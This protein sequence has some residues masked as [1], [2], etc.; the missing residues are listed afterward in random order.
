MNWAEVFER[1]VK[2]VET[3]CESIKTLVK[4]AE[5]RGTSSDRAG[6]TQAFYDA[7]T[8]PAGGRL[9]E[10][11]VAAAMREHTAVTGQ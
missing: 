11:S 4:A 9:W 1:L 10:I 3:L 7:P 6:T 5:A 2:A 8:F